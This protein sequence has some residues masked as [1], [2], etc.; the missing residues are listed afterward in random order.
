MP[1][2]PPAS[3]DQS[4]IDPAA[5]PPPH[6]PMSDDF[7]L[8]PAAFRGVWRRTLLEGAGLA[9]D[10]VSTVLWLQ[11]ARCHADLRLPAMRPV[12]AGV[13]SLAETDAPQ[14][15]WLAGQQ[16]FSGV[17]EVTDD[18]CQWHRD[19]DFQPP[20]GGRDIAT[21]IPHADGMGLEEYGIDD[22]YHESWVRLPESIGPAGVWLKRDT[23]PARLLV[24]GDCFFLVRP[25]RSRLVAGDPLQVLAQAQPEWLDFELSYGRIRGG[26]EPWQI[27]H[28]TLPWRE[29]QR[30]AADAWRCLYADHGAAAPPSR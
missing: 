15:A 4:L 2:L 1:S 6:C 10:T 20:T 14:R 8:V 3:P 17:T 5:T 21:V 27:L 30:L 24:A 26:A 19:L 23:T 12:F 18:T 9:T 25:R 13:A 29:G 28:S 7:P 16:G 22:E 11:T